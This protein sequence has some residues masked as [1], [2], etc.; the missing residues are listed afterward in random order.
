M[1]G[2]TCAASSSLCDQPTL[3]KQAIGKCICYDAQSHPV[4]HTAS[5]VQELSLGK[6][7]LQTDEQ[8]CTARARQW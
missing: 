2:L 5:W 3:L 4:L 8:K 7:L 6:N 1:H